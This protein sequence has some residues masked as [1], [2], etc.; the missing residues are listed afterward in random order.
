[1]GIEVTEGEEGKG[2]REPESQR[3]EETE[4]GASSPLY[5]VSV[6]PGCC[7]VTVGRSL[8]EMLTAMMLQLKMAKS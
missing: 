2:A 5:I 7:R 8:E 1:M 4:E 3:R 6:T